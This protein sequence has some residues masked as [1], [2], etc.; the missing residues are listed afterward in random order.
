MSEI[1]ASPYKKR[2]L[3]EKLLK[4]CL[5][6]VEFAESV[7]AS[8]GLL[9]RAVL[10]A[11]GFCCSLEEFAA[12]LSAIKTSLNNTSLLNPSEV[13][14]VAT[15]VGQA[16]PEDL[17]DLLQTVTQLGLTKNFTC[18]AEFLSVVKILAGS[19]NQ[20]SDFLNTVRFL[21]PTNFPAWNFFYT[22]CKKINIHE[23]PRSKFFEAVRHSRNYFQS[24]ESFRGILRALSEEPEYSRAFAYGQLDSKKWL[25][26][27][28]IKAWGKNWGQTV[29]VLAGW[30][31]LLPKMMCDQKIAT[32][33]IRSFDI[34]AKA[35]R[36]SEL[37]NQSEVQKDWSYKASTLD[38]RSMQYPTVYEVHRKDGS[39]CELVD[40]PDV[41][42][43]T[44]C[45]HIQDMNEWWL[46]IPKGTRVILQSNNGFHISD[47]VGCVESL[48]AFSK[49]MNLSQVD[50]AGEKDLPEFRRFMLIG[51]K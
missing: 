34:D 19:K 23:A 47:H 31:G 21:A 1:P 20:L 41:I 13:L 40:M 12:Y 39:S 51:T 26:E 16:Q 14:N 11:V 45:E 35:N 7:P 22:E 5:G 8:N 25:I 32:Q 43:N 15:I 46:Q 29:F 48:Q 37:I 6:V 38:I 42:I 30:V 18:W 27:E 2:V 3:D 36:I 33:K 50:F 10:D 24:A 49:V 17:Q 28:A 44:S 9:R 4:F